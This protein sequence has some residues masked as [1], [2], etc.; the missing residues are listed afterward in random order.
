[1]SL[2][3]KFIEE[4][5]NFLRRVQGKYAILAKS[6]LPIS[7]ESDIDILCDDETSK[8]IISYLEKNYTIKKFSVVS[9][10]FMKTI[11]IVF[12]DNSFLEIDLIQRFIRKNLEYLSSEEILQKGT[13]IKNGLSILKPEYQLLYILLFYTL[14]KK[15]IKAKYMKFFLSLPES[16]KTQ[17]LNFIKK[18]L[19]IN[20]SS[21]EDLLKNNISFRS[22]IINSL[23]KKNPIHKRIKFLI[24]YIK[25]I[26]TNLHKSKVITFNGV[27]GAGK[28]TILL[29]FKEVLEKK[30]R[31]NV[32]T[33]RH[34]PS[35]LPILS[36][37][38]YGKKE[39]EKR[40]LQRPPRTGENKSFLSSILRFSY[41][42]ID[43]LIGQWIVF[44]KYRLRGYIILYDRYYF[45]FIVDSKRSNININPNL[46][47][48]LYTFIH[49]PELNIFLYA[50]TE[51]ILSRKRELS[52]KDIET[53]TNKYLTLFKELNRKRPEIYVSIENINKQE[54]LKK[55]EELFQ[56]VL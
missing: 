9:Y 10:S 26:K 31:R 46:A 18:H 39:A 41:Y 5:L 1:M 25:D 35:L 4:L 50:P 43:Y 56:E 37:I 55:I 40:T 24:S 14:N 12:K 38:K 36:A 45:D 20:S 32:I 53:L 28:T 27:D 8:E 19:N 48:K 11:Y 54:T 33:L 44:A 17:L 2:R 29:N 13:N 6:D 49:K 16:K 51:I 42:Y 21:L 47:K 34:R 22:K 52:S 23:K 15:P 3:E 7:T 30:Y